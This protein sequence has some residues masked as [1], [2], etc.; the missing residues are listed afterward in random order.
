MSGR[1]YTEAQYSTPSAMEAIRGWLGPEPGPEDI[2]RVARYMSL[3]L[4]IGGMRICRAL[5]EGAIKDGGGT[6]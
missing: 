1:T 2:E 5:I 4:R 3:T 6:R